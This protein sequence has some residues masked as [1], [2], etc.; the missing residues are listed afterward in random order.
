LLGPDF[1]I[2]HLLLR[3]HFMTWSFIAAMGFGY[4]VAAKNPTQQTGLIL[5][6]GIGKLLAAATWI[7]MLI[8]GYGTP[9][10]IAGIF[11]DGRIGNSKPRLQARI[12]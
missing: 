1:T 2:D 10:M 9:L 7:E 8:H 11:T 5:A 4:W 3:Y 12:S 6:G